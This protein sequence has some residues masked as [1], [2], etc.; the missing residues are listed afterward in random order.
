MIERPMFEGARGSEPPEEG[1]HGLNVLDEE[2][3][4]DVAERQ[5]GSVPSEEGTGTAEAPR[6]P[7][8]PPAP[9]PKPT[10]RRG[11]RRHPDVAPGVTEEQ[12]LYAKFLAHG[13]HAG[14]ALLL[15]TFLLYITG[16]VEP[17]VPVGELS[18]YWT[19]DAGSYLREL[20]A[21][22]L[23]QEHGLNGW[24]WLLAPTRADCMNFLG[25]VVLAMVTLVCFLGILPTLI[26]KRDWIY[27]AIAAVQVLILALAVSGIFAAGG[28]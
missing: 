18:S 13:M 21:N 26:R 27:A 2:P 12:L 23:H 4:P 7:A 8:A 19:L 6:P 10:K 20:N 9:P 22:Y 16:F 28:H 24:W 14:L 25:V 11:A 17:L 15:T 1:R 3:G 5:A